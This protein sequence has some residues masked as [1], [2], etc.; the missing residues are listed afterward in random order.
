[1]TPYIEVT[2]IG[3]WTTTTVTL[4]PCTSENF[5]LGVTIDPA[6]PYCTRDT[7]TIEATSA[8]TGTV[9]GSGSA[10]AH[11][12]GPELTLRGVTVDIHDDY[13]EAVL[14]IDRDAVKKRYDPLTFKVV[15]TNTGDL[16]DKYVI[17]ATTESDKILELWPTE[18][19]LQPDKSDFV[20][21]SVS[22]PEDEV[23]STYN[24]ITVTAT[25]TFA[26]FTGDDMN[27]TAGAD[28]CTVHIKEAYCVR[29]DVWPFQVQSATP[30]SKVRWIARVKNLGN[31]VNTYTVDVNNVVIDAN[32]EYEP[33]VISVTP[34]GPIELQPC[35]WAQVVI[36]LDVPEGLEMSTRIYVTVDVDSVLEV[37]PD[38]ADSAEVEVHVVRGIPPIPQG[39]IKLE[40]ETEI[41]AIQVW[42]TYADFGIL[43]EAETAISGPFTVRN[44]GNKPVDVTITGNDAKSSP[45]ELTT[46]W[47]LSPDLGL[48]RYK[49]WFNGTVLDK[50]GKLLVGSL[51]VSEEYNFDLT[52]QAPSS[53]T[54]PSRMWT[55]VNLMALEA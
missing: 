55:L 51:Q 36:D 9:V 10:I 30:G 24:D 50:A 2:Y 14:V 35:N 20:V 6:A 32:R 49:M 44:I 43:D 29:V 18:L 5:D 21:L 41:I 34:E 13:Q 26:T 52:I 40:V 28:T 46:T 31:T 39:V 54:V 37:A 17:T 47:D 48:D 8:Y 3:A 22:I 23:G 4:E 45:G 15:V 1:M 19:F 7:L 25:G 27:N 33:A 16:W 11:S 53:I 38:C 42:P 12:L